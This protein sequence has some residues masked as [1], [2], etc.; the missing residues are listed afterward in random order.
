MGAVIALSVTRHNKNSF[1]SMA[2]FQ[3]VVGHTTEKRYVLHP[4]ENARCLAFDS[5]QITFIVSA[6][7]IQ[8][9]I[10]IVRYTI[11]DVKKI[12]NQLGTDV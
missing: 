9:S 1:Q 8:Q 7:W 12:S 11:Q 2:V 3:A 5:F 4:E 10:K 6:Q